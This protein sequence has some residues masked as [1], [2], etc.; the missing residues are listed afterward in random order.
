MLRHVDFYAIDAATMFNITHD[1]FAAP[2]NLFTPSCFWFE[3]SHTP[4]PYISRH[5]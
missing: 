5:Y 3:L 1:I 4:M 2:D